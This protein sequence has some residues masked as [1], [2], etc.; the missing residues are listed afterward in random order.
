M[1]LKV[2][3]V[4][5]LADFFTSLLFYYTL[6]SFVTFSFDTHQNEQCKMNLHIV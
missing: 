3:W 1:K 6:I 5:K 2:M 4:I